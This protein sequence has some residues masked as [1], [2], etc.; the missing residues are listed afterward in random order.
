MKHKKSINEI[1]VHSAKVAY[2]IY[3]QKTTEKEQLVTGKDSVNAQKTHV[4]IVEDHPLVAETYAKLLRKIEQEVAIHFEITIAHHGEAA[5][6]RMTTQRFAIIFLDLN[7][8]KSRLEMSYSG[9]ELVE[10]MRAHLTIMPKII[11]SSAFVELYRVRSV[12]KRINPDAFMSKTDQTMNDVK[13]A[14]VAILAN[15][16]YYSKTISKMMEQNFI[17]STHIDAIDRELLFELSL[18][19]SMDKMANKMFVSKRVL[20]HRKK[21][22]KAF[23]NVEDDGELIKMAIEKGYI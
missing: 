20:Y 23:F 5:M 14:V 11:V 2:H 6:Y 7:L 1:D 19:T 8:R 21:E 18:H 9:E 17:N 10:W 16:T 12:F 3:D 22:L 4:L 15:G 13:N